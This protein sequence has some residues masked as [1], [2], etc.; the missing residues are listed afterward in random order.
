[1]L[2]FRSLIMILLAACLH[3]ASLVT[4]SVAAPKKGVPVQRVH[5]VV[6]QV[7]DNDPKVMNPARTHGA[8]SSANRGTPRRIA[9]ACEQ[10][11]HSTSPDMI[12][13]PSSSSTERSR[14]VAVHKG[15][16]R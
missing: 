5:K 15:Q 13:I 14:M 1:M 8:A 6:I 4:P 16:A 2:S 11:V 7:N 9:K 12:S 10:D 3:S